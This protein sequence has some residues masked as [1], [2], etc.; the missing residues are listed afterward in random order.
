M[1]SVMRFFFFLPLLTQ[2]VISIVS[3]AVPRDA[4]ITQ[5]EPSDQNSHLNPRDE[6]LTY[7]AKAMDPNNDDE[8]KQ[9]REFLG[10]AVVDKK[11]FITSFKARDG[12]LFVWGGLTLDD[13]ALEKAR[14]YPNIKFVMEEPK[15]S[16]D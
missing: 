1:T 14:S 16:Y 9:T 6:R 11:A 2:V 3:N 12:S 4:S 5:P 13:A 7:M 15:I 10:N 8:I